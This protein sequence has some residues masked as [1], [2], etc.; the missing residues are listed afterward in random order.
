MIEVALYR[1]GGPR[2]LRAFRDPSRAL[3]SEQFFYPVN[4][5][6]RLIHN[7]PQQSLEILAG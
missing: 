2:F 4:D 1:G 5:L 7:L 6:S 3:I